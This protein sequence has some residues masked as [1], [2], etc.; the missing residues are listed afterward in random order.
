MPYFLLAIERVS[1]RGSGPQECALGH[2]LCGTSRTATLW[3]DSWRDSVAGNTE[4]FRCR[5]CLL[6]EGLNLEGETRS[7]LYLDTHREY[8]V[9]NPQG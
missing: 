2:T 5:E 6:A 8:R 3:L 9:R 7:T 1:S 4:Y